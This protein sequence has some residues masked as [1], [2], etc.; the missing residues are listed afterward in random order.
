MFGDGFT[1]RMI[2]LKHKKTVDAVGRPQV[3]SLRPLVSFCDATSVSLRTDEYHRTA[4]ISGIAGQRI[5]LGPAI[6]GP[7]RGTEV[8]LQVG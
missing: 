5:F 7:H 8:C 2:Y 4:L 3:R 1:D 6:V